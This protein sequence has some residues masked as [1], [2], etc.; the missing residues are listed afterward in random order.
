M[1]Y[2]SRL[3]R[4]LKNKMT[5]NRDL[6][7]KQKN[8][9]SRHKSTVPVASLKISSEAIRGKIASVNRLK[10]LNAVE[11]AIKRIKAKSNVE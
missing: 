1:K 7:R 6:E 8:L 9:L 4:R 2:I 5:M 10:R 11:K 3:V